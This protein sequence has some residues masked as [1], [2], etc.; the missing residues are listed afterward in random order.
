[1]RSMA[2]EPKDEK[3]FLLGV[4]NGGWH[5]NVESSRDYELNDR[6]TLFFHSKRCD[7]SIEISCYVSGRTLSPIPNRQD[8]IALRAFDTSRPYII[9]LLRYYP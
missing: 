7:E 5:L 3:E 4:L 2:I 1:M 6:I 9:M 8:R